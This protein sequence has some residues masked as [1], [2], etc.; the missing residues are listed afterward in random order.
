[1]QVADV[2]QKFMTPSQLARR[3]ERVVY[4]STLDAPTTK[5]MQDH[6]HDQT[7]QVVNTSLSVWYWFCH[8]ITQEMIIVDL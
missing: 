1:M 6:T 8:N 2:Q 4:T 5:Q 7:P 3:L